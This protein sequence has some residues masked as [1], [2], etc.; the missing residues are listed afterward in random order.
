MSEQFQRF[1]AIFIRVKQ[2]RAKHYEAYG[3]AENLYKRKY[4]HRAYR[5]YNSFKSQMSKK[6]RR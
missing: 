2:Y 5:N 3:L 4:G 6:P 1:Y